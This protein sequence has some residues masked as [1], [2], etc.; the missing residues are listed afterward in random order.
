MVIDTLHFLVTQLDARGGLLESERETFLFNV[1]ESLRKLANAGVFVLMVNNAVSNFEQGFG[2]GKIKAA[3]GDYYGNLIDERLK[4]AKPNS[5][6][7]SRMNKVSGR[8]L[9]VIFSQRLPKK[10]IRVMI[11][12]AG[13]SGFEKDDQL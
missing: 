13:V 10:K 11:H 5:F 1:F 6:E 9:E 2:K 12:D 7:Q 4:I 3:M 8:T